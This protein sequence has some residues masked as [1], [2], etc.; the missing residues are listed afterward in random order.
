[1]RERWGRVLDGCSHRGHQENE[2]EL[3]RAYK[4]LSIAALE[5]AAEVAKAGATGGADVGVDKLLEIA[6]VY[7]TPTPGSLT[8]G[9]RG[10]SVRPAERTDFFTTSQGRR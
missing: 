3:L 10:R 8:S 5:E 7:F 4:N 1:M 2:S 9:P 6:G